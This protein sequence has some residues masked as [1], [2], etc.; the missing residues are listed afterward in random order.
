VPD[1]V[2]AKSDA[3][4]NPRTAFRMHFLVI[5]QARPIATVLTHVI[6]ELRTKCPDR[7]IEAEVA[8]DNCIAC[9]PVRIAQLFS[10]LLGNAVSYGA[11]DEPI[12]WLTRCEKWHLEHEAIEAR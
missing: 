6:D 1:R 7:A 8:L 12:Q 3:Y 10:N 11:A 2:I 5:N 4:G 9:D